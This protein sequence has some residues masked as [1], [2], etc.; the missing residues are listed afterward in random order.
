MIEVKGYQPLWEPEF[1]RLLFS[2]VISTIGYWSTRLALFA[3]YAFEANTGVLAIGGLGI[4]GYLPRILGAPVAGVV[5]DRF[6][7]RNI[8]I[9]TELLSIG[10]V[11]PLALFESLLF[12]YVAFFLL[13]LLSSAAGPAYRAL[14]PRLVAEDELEEANALNSIGGSISQFVGPGLAG[15]LLLVIEPKTLFLVDAA[16]FVV[17]ALLLWRMS[18][19]DAEVDPGSSFLSDIRGI[20]HDVFQNSRIIVVT[21]VGVF[22]YMAI[23]SFEAMFP[24]FLRD[25]MKVES[26]AYGFFSALVAVG[27]ISVGMLIGRYGNALSGFSRLATFLVIGGVAFVIPSVTTTIPA[28]ALVSVMAGIL[29]TGLI[30]LMF[31]ELQR[32]SDSEVMGR[33]SGTFNSLT[34]LGLVIGMALGSWVAVETTVTTSFLLGGVLLFLTAVSLV[35]IYTTTDVVHEAATT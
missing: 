16:T 10:L 29:S 17:S 5:A 7:K 3:L 1:R 25:V 11:V 18:T 19:Y 2:D 9:L 8:L 24:V 6:S 14:I 27:S 21:L 33:V 32:M 34:E 22:A 15:V 13:G 35:V 12:A 28:I 4:A 31:S 23:G 20:F 26:S 30:T